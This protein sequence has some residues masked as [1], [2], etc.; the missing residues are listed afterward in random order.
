MPLLLGARLAGS[1]D[2]LLRGRSL[3]CLGGG[4]QGPGH[5]DAA[6]SWGV[7]AYRQRAMNE[8]RAMGWESPS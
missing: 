6:G 4:S 2:A 7:E 3:R 5:P 8:P 1:T